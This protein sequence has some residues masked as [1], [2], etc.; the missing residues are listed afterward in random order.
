MTWRRL[1][2]AVCRETELSPSIGRPCARRPRFVTTRERGRTPYE[3]FLATIPMRRVA[4]DRKV[5]SSVCTFVGERRFRNATATRSIPNAATSSAPKLHERRLCARGGVQLNEPTAASV[6]STQVRPG[7]NV[8]D[9]ASLIERKRFLLNLTF[10]QGHC[11]RLR[12]GG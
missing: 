6:E 11:E 8:H 10:R 7:E 4:E 2:N 12:S 5:N 1:S 9:E 3:R